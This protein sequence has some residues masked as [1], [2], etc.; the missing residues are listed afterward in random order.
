MKKN[1]RVGVF[2]WGIVAPRSPNIE[3]FQKNLAAAQTWLAPFNGFGPDNFLVGTP[4]FHL[5]DYQ[6]WVAERFLPRRFQQLKEKMDFPSL[7]A[8]G[9]FI[10]SLGQNPGI[11]AELQRLGALCHVY[12]G[13][14]VGN[15]ATMYDESVRLYKAQRKWNEFWGHPRN[16][17]ALRAYLASPDEA[18]TVPPNLT[19]PHD[20]APFEDGDATDAWHSYWTNRSIEL[21]TYLAELAQ[22]ESLAIEGDIGT[23]KLRVLREKERLYGKLQQK[24]GAPDPPWK[25]SAN[26]IWNI[27]NTPAA[28]VSMLGRITGM[29]FAP[30]A[31]C[32]SF[33]VGLRLAIRA[34]QAGDATAVVVGATDPPP[35]PLIVG[36]FHTAR[37]LSANGEVSAPLT[38]FQGTHIAGGGAVWI[39]ADY[40]HMRSLGFQPV[41]MELLSVGVSSD[42]HHIITP[43]QAGPRTAIAQA[44]DE[45][46]VTPDEL[47]SWDLHATATPGDFSEVETMAAMLPRTVLA[48]ARKGTF[49]HGMSV[50]GAWELTAQ[51]L[52]YQTGT[53]F[54]TSFSSAELNPAI[55]GLHE[56]FVFDTACAAPPGAVGKL[57]MGVGGV[58]AC[59]ISR[60]WT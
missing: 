27:H 11:E 59:V 53:L 22:I 15:V 1:A 14:G 58:N 36:S 34:I 3:A 39:V 21:R 33:G 25:V 5:E 38:R 17:S 24:W 52:G 44:L 43:N 40:D 46:G 37:V 23:G 51:Y 60:P 4:D 28:Q 26:V 35:H 47:G 12:I 18:S 10:Q 16:N 49:G 56:R 2:G 30:V 41:G 9:A 42:A 55:A 54:P 29:T 57:S 8:I 32:S 31:A 7:Y 20:S 6:G 19:A 45:A 13:T 48:T 50:G